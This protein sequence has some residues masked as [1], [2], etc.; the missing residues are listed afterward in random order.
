MTISI[1]RYSH[2]ALAVSSVVFILLASITGAILA[3]QPISE[4]LAPYKVANLD[5]V[6]VA[7]T[8][9]VFKETYP[10]VIDIKVDANHFVIASVF[11]ENGDNLEGYFNPVTAEFLGAKL[12]PSKFF[13]WVTN[14]HRSLFLKSV[15]RFFV[16]LCSFLL[17]VIAIT[18]TILIV[19]RQRGIQQFFA[20]IVNENFSQYWH[21]VLGRLSLIP[22]II[23][24][25]TGVYLSLEKFN[26]L[27]E[28][29]EKH[30][31]DFNTISEIPKRDVSEFELFQNTPLS[32]VETLEFPFSDD[33]EDYFTLKL[34]QEELVVN[35]YTGE[36]LSSLKAPMVEV[37][38]NL[39][40]VLHTGRGN[41][42]W[43]FIL[44][45]ASI[46]ILFF[47]Y[48][49]FD[50]TL[51][52]RA[53][54][55]KNKFRREECQ[56]IILVG[57]ENGS[58][59]QYANAFYKQLIEAG[60]KVFITELNDYTQFPKAEHLIAFT[61]T[62]GQGEAPTNADKFLEQLKIIKQP[63]KCRYAVV[64]FGSLAYPDFCQ[65]AY[66][67]DK[68]MEVYFERAME[69][70]TINDKSLEAFHQFVGSWSANVGLTVEIPEGDLVP[71][72][73]QT[74]KIKVVAKTSVS[75]NL[76]ST[77]LLKL[78][79]KK[80]QKF[81]SGDLLAIYPKNDYRE[82]LYSIGKVDGNIQLSIKFYEHGLGSNYLNDLLVGDKFKAKIIKNTSFHFPVKA[83]KVILI[84]NGTGVAPFL[85]MLHQN[86][87]HRETKLYLGL[88]TQAS[89]NLYQPQIDALLLQKKLNDFELVL[90]REAEQCYVQDKLHDN[91][92]EIAQTLYNGGVIMLCGSLAM[93][94]GVLGVLESICVEF[95]HKPLS[96]YQAQGQLKMDCY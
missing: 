70:T 72:R 64:G 35:Q 84:A 1:W 41:T 79:P 14:F 86:K 78:K 12:Q 13:Q 11:T 73:K 58:T 95:T 46:N 96:F 81:T 6:S 74:K 87:K 5:E 63:N 43:A 26:L 80:T 60:E 34:K 15:G 10:E 53:S 83:P 77:F 93:Q 89:F 7:K 8:V 94:K 57:S 62:Y 23:I 30:K 4:Q 54:G 55:L 50:M 67:I 82:R 71:N 28:S 17:F 19:K 85:G 88:R 24:T 69:V 42:I 27:P 32:E 2:L 3:F 65:F 47:I 21:V 37:V 33:V 36:V 90:S 76:D 16:G 22:I 45:L 29:K 75:D 52:R 39:S 68:A 38:T 40:M 59:M 31:I 20:K 18:G 44:G 61:A 51:K 91:A 25:L 66:D 56:Y 92:S 9:E 49:G 48:S